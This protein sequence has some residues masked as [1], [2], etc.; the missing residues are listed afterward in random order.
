MS[1]GRGLEAREQVGNLALLRRAVQREKGRG[2]FSERKEGGLD[3]GGPV[4]IGRR[5]DAEVL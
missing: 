2:T 3:P 4:E 1:Q 5:S